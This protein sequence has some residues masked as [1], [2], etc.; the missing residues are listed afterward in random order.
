MTR[1]EFDTWITEHY[2]ELIAVAKRRGARSPQDVVQQAA[3]AMYSTQGYLRFDRP[4]TWAVGQVRGALSTERLSGSRRG[5]LA[6]AA[7]DVV[8]AADSSHR[9]KRP[10]PRAE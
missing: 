6:R 9:R 7:T 5:R 8:R 4:W 2:G 1:Q 3:V 10:A